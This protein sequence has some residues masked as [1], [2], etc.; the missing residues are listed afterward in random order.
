MKAL[1]LKQDVVMK[2]LKA[3]ILFLL[4]IFCTFAEEEVLQYQMIENDVNGN[5]I[6][7]YLF[8]NDEQLDKNIDSIIKNTTD[9]TSDS[10]MPNIK[11]IKEQ[12]VSMDYI[13]SNYPKTY[14]NLEELRTFEIL[15]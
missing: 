10:Y 7:T 12:F 6:T 11:T 2:K 9:I 4:L 15:Q 3:T 13:K 5:T 1:A 8:K 14:E